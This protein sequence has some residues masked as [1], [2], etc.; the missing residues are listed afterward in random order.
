MIGILNIFSLLYLTAVVAFIMGMGESDEPKE[1]ARH[2]LGCWAKLLGGLVGIGVV[3][4]I[5]S[6]L[7]G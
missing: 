1:A 7:A 3:V 2:V 4:Y 5:L 6:L